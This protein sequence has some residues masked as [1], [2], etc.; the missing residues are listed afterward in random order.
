MPDLHAR[1]RAFD[2][3]QPP[4][5][6]AEIERRAAAL[7]TMPVAPVTA[8]SASWR[9]GRAPDQPG[10]TRRL[11]LALVVLA[12]ALAAVVGAAV[13]GGLFRD[14]LLADVPPI[15]TQPS[16]QP[17]VTDATQSTVAPSSQPSPSVAPEGRPEAVSTQ[18]FSSALYGYSIRL[19]G[20]WASTPAT[21]A[22][23]GTGD[24]D[25]PPSADTMSG[26]GAPD[27]SGLGTGATH[28]LTV[29]AADVPVGT[30]LETWTDAHPIDRD[31]YWPEIQACRVRL[32]G[33]GSRMFPGGPG[34]WSGGF[35]GGHPAQ[36]RSECGYLDGV[37]IVDDRIYIFSLLRAWV[38]DFGTYERLTRT[39][40][41]GDQPIPAPVLTTFTS[42]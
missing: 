30:T 4:D 29:V 37:V 26:E 15:I 42:T 36:V 39:V 14:R 5:L 12:L 9:G 1:F 19:P 2:G 17:A 35:I 31:L 28:T 32:S 23:S 24:W 16:P 6:W 22:W 21:S 3:I 20:G 11:V 27:P 34:T 8:G 33:G 38:L 40:T 18:A 13:A 41:F 10:S 25:Q 7:P